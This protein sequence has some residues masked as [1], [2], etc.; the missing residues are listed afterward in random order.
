VV[1]LAGFFAELCPRGRGDEVGL[2]KGHLLLF[3]W[4]QRVGLRC[5]DGLD[6][7]RFERCLVSKSGRH[8]G[9]IL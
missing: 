1:G 4:R 8:C 9:G 7:E 3:L 2:R 6:G 5:A